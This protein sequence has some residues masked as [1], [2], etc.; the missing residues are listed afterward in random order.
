[1]L[2]AAENQMWTEVD[3]DDDPST[4]P[5]LTFGL[6]AENSRKATWRTGMIRIAVANIKSE[7]RKINRFRFI[8]LL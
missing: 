5:N 8:A 6:P 4:D 2:G 7:G 3:F 1:M